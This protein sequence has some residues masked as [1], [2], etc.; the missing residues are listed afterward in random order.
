MITSRFSHH[1]AKPL[2]YKY[3]AKNC[4]YFLFWALLFCK[5]NG[6]SYFCI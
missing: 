1:I 2:S 6:F 5:T 3:L 4:Y